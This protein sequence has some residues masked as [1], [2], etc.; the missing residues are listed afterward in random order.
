M[1]KRNKGVG[2]LS[3]KLLTILVLSGMATLGHAADNSI[4]IDQ[5]GDNSTI[6][7]TQDGAGNK[8]KGI[9][10]S[11]V[12]G[13]TTDPA[14]LTGNAQT[15]NIE[16]TGATNVLALGVNST[17]GGLVQGYANIGV[18]LNYQVSGGGNTGYI[19]INNNGQGTAIGNVVS[20]IQSGG[21][22]TATLNMTGTSN[23]LTVGQSGGANNTFIGTINADETVATVSNT[24]GGGN[25][26]TLDMTGNKGQVS[27]T[28]TG[29]TNTTSVTQSAFGST[30]AQVLV[31][32]DG[33]GNNT[34]VTQSGM[35]DHYASLSVVGSGNN[36]T[37]AQSGGS[38]TGHSATLSVTGSTNTVG[39]TQQ[40][41][42]ANLTNMAVNGS[43]NTYT[44][45]QK[46]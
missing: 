21:G 32:I 45:L 18:N 43:N 38:A 40:G 44:I 10:S 5:A 37:I 33:S 9:L 11:G 12:A 8:V 24:L 36:F 2:K 30:G 19:N 41:S 13:G 7:M 4:Y 22:G 42:V 16:Q 20:I 29:T 15:V 46:N 39:I 28:T 25:T 31:N 1:D 6:T 27:V 26:T 23:Q 34:T 35:Y 17:Q 14:K 3:R